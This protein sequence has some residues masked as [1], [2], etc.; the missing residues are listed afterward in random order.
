MEENLNK[1]I[2]KN[3]IKAVEKF[4]EELRKWAE[5]TNGN[6]DEPAELYEDI[7]TPFTLTNVRVEDG[8]LNYLYDGREES[9]KMVRQWE[10]TGEW[11]EV[12]GL[13][14]IP[15]YLKFW[16]ACLRRAKRYFAMDP[17]KLDRLS[18]GEEDDEDDEDAPN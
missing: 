6:P 13:D 17:D 5:Y 7:N 11:E 4:N 3:H 1:Y 2:K 8:C 16:K 9:E 10:D 14:S 12:E 18:E 15:D